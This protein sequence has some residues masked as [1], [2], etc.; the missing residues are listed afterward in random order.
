MDAKTKEMAALSA[1]VAARCQPCFRYH[2]KKARELG[3]NEAEIM[4]VISLAHRISEMGDKRMSEFVDK[5]L[6]E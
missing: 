3:I 5:A 4:E 1:S 6:V 2:L